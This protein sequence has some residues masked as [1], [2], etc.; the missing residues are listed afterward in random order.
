M[1]SEAPTNTLAPVELGRG[2][3]MVVLA[4]LAEVSDPLPSDDGSYVTA[5]DA[6]VLK[7]Q[8]EGWRVTVDT[9]PV[10]RRGATEPTYLTVLERA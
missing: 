2:N 6:V 4:S 8:Q 1:S 7:A 9:M 5:H 10:W 3:I